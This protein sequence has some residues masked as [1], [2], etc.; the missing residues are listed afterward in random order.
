MCSGDGCFEIDED[1]LIE[2]D[3]ESQINYEIFEDSAISE[4]S[5][6]EVSPGDNDL[7][8]STQSR[9]NFSTFFSGDRTP[10]AKDLT[11]K[12]IDCVVYFLD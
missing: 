9:D 3:G 7:E 2:Q 12:G 8:T 6:P 11:L 5:L 1:I 4:S 10:K